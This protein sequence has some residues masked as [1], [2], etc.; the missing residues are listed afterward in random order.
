MTVTKAP[1]KIVTSNRTSP[2]PGRTGDPLSA[3]VPD[4]PKPKLLLHP[5]PEPWTDRC[6]QSSR[7]SLTDSG[8]FYADPYKTPK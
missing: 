5:C 3:G 6:T 4:H 2:A 1:L 7:R 8:D